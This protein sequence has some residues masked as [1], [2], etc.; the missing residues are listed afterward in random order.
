M[1]LTQ[2]MKAMSKAKVTKL[3]DKLNAVVYTDRYDGYYADAP[4]GFVFAGSDLHTVG[5]DYDRDW[6]PMREVWEYFVDEFESGI[7]ECEEENCEA[8]AAE[9]AEGMVVIAGGQS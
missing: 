2:R 8:C 1:N 9:L 5:C 6:M 4:K 3:A 7:T